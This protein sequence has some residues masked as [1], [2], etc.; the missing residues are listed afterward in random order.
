MSHF[1]VLHLLP[2]A[3][4]TVFIFGGALPLWDG[5]SAI[6]EFGLP[7]HIALSREAQVTFSIYG[8]RMTAWGMA[9]W[10]FYIK[11]NLRAFDTMLGL[12]LYVSLVDGYVCWQEGEQ[13]RGLFRVGCGVVISAWG[14][15]GLTRRLGLA[16]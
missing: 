11:G 10:T 1:H 4:A 14:F 13:D 8:S 3:L 12:L 16:G 7:E 2:L 5:A 15:V 6:R 9:L